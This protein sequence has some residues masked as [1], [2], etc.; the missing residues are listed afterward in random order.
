VQEAEYTVYPNPTTGVIH[1]E[2]ASGFESIKQILVYNVAGKMIRNVD[3]PVK[4]ENIYTFDL[5]DQTTG[6]YIVK[7]I[8]A[9]LTRQFKVLLTR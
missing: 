6:Y 4:P 1:V 3:L 7:I 8:G 5:S 9:D 2:A